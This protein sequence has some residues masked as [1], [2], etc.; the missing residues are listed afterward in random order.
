M[1][2]RE[3]E[4]EQLRDITLEYMLEDANLERELRSVFFFFYGIMMEGPN[5]EREVTG[6]SFSQRGLNTLLVVKSVLGDIPQVAFVT[7]KFPIGCITTFGRQW[8]QD[9]VK[10]HS[11]KYVTT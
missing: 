8:L 5:N 7:E 10:W 6:C 9:R 11:D 4:L 3:Q 1:F 2:D